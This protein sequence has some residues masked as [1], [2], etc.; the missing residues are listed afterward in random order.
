MGAVATGG[1]KR[2]R[3]IEGSPKSGKHNRAEDS[4]AEEEM[5]KAQGFSEDS[6]G[7]RAGT[8]QQLERRQ[9][10]GTTGGSR[11]KLPRPTSSSEAKIR[12]SLT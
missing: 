8:P 12:S 10:M 1:G 4:T 5:T 2:W 9:L 11:R 7:T 6:Y 3:Q